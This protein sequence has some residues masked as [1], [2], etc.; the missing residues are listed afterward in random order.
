MRR[1]FCGRQVPRPRSTACTLHCTALHGHLKYLCDAAGIVVNQ[2]LPEARH[3]LTALI[4]EH[5]Q[6]QVTG[7]RREEVRTIL[8]TS[9]AIVT[10]VSTIRNN[11][12]LAHANDQLLDEHEAMLV[13]NMT[14]SL[15][16]YLDAKL[17][18]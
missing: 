15:L 14:K 2:E 11:A 12:S 8:R 18:A 4:N 9:L 1:I 16:R 17:G 5:R 10:A 6:L 7:P 13:I 3:Y